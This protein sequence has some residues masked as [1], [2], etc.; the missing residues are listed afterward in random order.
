MLLLEHA[1]EPTT[2][3]EVDVLT[4]VL[5]PCLEGGSG[6]RPDEEELVMPSLL[7]AAVERSRLSR[8]TPRAEDSLLL[9][10][11]GGADASSC[12][13]RT[14]AGGPCAA[15]T[16]P[17]GPRAPPEFCS[18][19]GMEAPPDATPEARSDGSSSCGMEAPPEAR[20][21]RSELADFFR[22]FTPKTFSQTMTCF[23]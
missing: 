22:F 1:R 20:L 2:S 19:C 8:E 23:S 3:F 9:L 21:I 18:S 12:E 13:A 11:G 16:L 7:D 10:D 4:G 6:P 15:K 17:D 5:F 14:G